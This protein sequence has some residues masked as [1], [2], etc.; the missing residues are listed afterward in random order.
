MSMMIRLLFPLIGYL[1]VA[2]VLSAG[3]GYGYLRRSGALNDE[4]MFRVVALLHGIDLEELEKAG[5]EDGEAAPAEEASFDEQQQLAQAA[6]IQSD[7]KRK[8]LADSLADFEFQLRLLDEKTGKYATFRE[9]VEEYLKQQQDLV[10][11]EQMQKVR[12]QLEAVDPTAQAKPILVKM[13]EDKRTDEV[14]L[15]LGSMKARSQRDILNTFVTPTDLEML[16]LIQRKMLAGEPALPYINE[17]LEELEQLKE[18]EK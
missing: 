2:T 3:L 16:Y 18:Q 15:L 13:I 1:C 4:T 10:M 7:A 9:S 14:I 12:A 11:K 17:R 8:Q 6:T 5:S